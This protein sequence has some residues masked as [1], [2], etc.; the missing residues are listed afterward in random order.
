MSN[1]KRIFLNVHSESRT[2][3]MKTIL[4]T[5]FMNVFSKP[6]DNDSKRFFIFFESSSSLRP[7][8]EC[9]M[10]KKFLSKHTL[11]FVYSF[12]SVSMLCLMFTNINQC[13]CKAIHFGGRISISLN[14]YSKQFDK[15]GICLIL[16]IPLRLMI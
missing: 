3:E 4:L 7:S 16:K 14:M 12:R 8:V 2:N 15:A 6:K 11:G 9:E 10:Q 1:I 13:M 5:K